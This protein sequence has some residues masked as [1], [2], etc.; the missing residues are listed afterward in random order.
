ME[1]GEFLQARE[2]LAELE[3]DY[4]EA[5]LETNWIETDCYGIDEVFN[6]IIK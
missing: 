2:D 1:E 6:K 5:G 4:R 3:D